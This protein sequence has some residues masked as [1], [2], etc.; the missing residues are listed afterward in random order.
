MNCM[1][2]WQSL[3]EDVRHQG[4]DNDLRVTRIVI[5]SSEKSPTALCNLGI[6]LGISSGSAVGK[7]GFVD[8]NGNLQ[9]RTC[10]TAGR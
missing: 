7:E 1:M 10:F 3:I 2:P 9:I 4:I 6:A 5:L 8:A